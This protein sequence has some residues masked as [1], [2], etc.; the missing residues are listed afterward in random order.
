MAVPLLF[1]EF[2]LLMHSKQT[3][4]TAIVII[5]REAKRQ[6]RNERGTFQFNY[7]LYASK[8]VIFHFM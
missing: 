7:D 6:A 5:A 1:D 3:L 4:L 8:S 2:S